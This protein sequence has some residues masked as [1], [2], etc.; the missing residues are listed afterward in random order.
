MKR[1]VTKVALSLRSTIIL[2]IFKSSK[3]HEFK[4][5]LWRTENIQNNNPGFAKPMRHEFRVYLGAI[6]QT[7]NES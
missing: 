4:I 7:G 5:S 2:L 1:A 6:F 3:P